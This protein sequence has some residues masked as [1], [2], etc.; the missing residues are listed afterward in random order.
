VISNDPQNDPRSG[1]LPHGHPP[2]K[3]YIGIPFFKNDEIMGM[4]GLAN[5]PGGYTEDFADQ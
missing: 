4:L 1:G 3:N 5:R 2:M